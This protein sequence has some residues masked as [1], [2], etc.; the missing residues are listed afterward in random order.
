MITTVNNEDPRYK[1]DRSRSVEVYRNLHK[2]CYSV[3]QDGLVKGH[4]DEVYLIDCTFHV[5]EKG[6]DRVR[7]KKRKE[8]HAWV[9]GRITEDYNTDLMPP[10]NYKDKVHYNPYSHDAFMT[11]WSLP[12]GAEI[13]R[14]H[15]L[16]D[17][18]MAFLPIKETK[19]VVLKPEG[20]W[21]LDRL[22]EL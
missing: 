15:G 11:L 4:T 22:L 18:T 6:R 16:P 17:Q 14:G 2:N 12:R 10:P 1:I 3:K 19:I 20:M 5:N 8:V 9:K 7:R 21:K 13:P